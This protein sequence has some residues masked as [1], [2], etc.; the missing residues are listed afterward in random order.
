MGLGCVPSEQQAALAG[1]RGPQS[2]VPWNPH[3]PSVQAHGSLRWRSGCGVASLRG[4]RFLVRRSG[5]SKGPG[6]RG[7]VQHPRNQWSMKWPPETL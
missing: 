7:P 1:T 4:R 2:H 5:H 3:G 6:L